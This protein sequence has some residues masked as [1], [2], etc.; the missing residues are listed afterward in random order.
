MLQAEG[1]QLLRS[2]ADKRHPRRLA[3]LGEGRVF[4]QKA[5]AGVDRFGAALLRGGEDL[6]RHQ[7]G[8]RRRAVAEA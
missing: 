4:R 2:G 1:A 8:L 7:I 3:G 6:L 5:V